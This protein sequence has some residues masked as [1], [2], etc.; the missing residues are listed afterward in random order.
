MSGK[1]PRL[2]RVKGN[3]SKPK[4]GQCDESED[5]RAGKP[6]EKKVKSHLLEYLTLPM[7][8]LM[9]AVADMVCKLNF[10]NRIPF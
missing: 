8:V 6:F 1:G 5:M 9:G 4:E 2:P 3:I 7:T 10:G